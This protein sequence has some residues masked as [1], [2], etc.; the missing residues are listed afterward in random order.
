VPPV[1]SNDHA[2]EGSTH[3]HPSKK[4]AIVDGMVVVQKMTKKPATVVTVKDFSECFNASVLSLT[5]GFDHIILVSDTYKQDSLKSTTRSKRRHGKAS[6]QY[7][8]KDDTNIKH[9][10]MS[11]FLSH[12]RTKADLANYLANK[13]LEYNRYSDKV[14][15]VSASGL[16]SSNG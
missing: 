13:T 3:V 1:P 2:N 10:T 5:R 6:V 16:T 7:Q 8:V 12:E 4:L 15:V 11:R 9:I 14:I